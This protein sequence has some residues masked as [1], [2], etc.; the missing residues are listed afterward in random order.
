MFAAGGGSRKPHSTN[1]TLGNWPS[2]SGKATSSSTDCS[3]PSRQP[4]HE[5]EQ[6]GQRLWSDVLTGPTGPHLHEHFD[7]SAQDLQVWIQGTAAL[8]NLPWE[9]LTRENRFVFFEENVPLAR[10]IPHNT[11][12]LGWQQAR[13]QPKLRVLLVPAQPRNLG[14]VHG[15]ET[16]EE[17]RQRLWFWQALG[18]LDLEVLDHATDWNTLDRLR[19]RLQQRRGFDVVCLLAHGEAEGPHEAGGP[20]RIALVGAHGEPD[21]LAAR[22]LVPPM[23]SGGEL[24]RLV[25][26]GCCHLGRSDSRGAFGGI[27]QELLEQ[28]IPAV[29]S[30]QS[31]VSTQGAAVAIH[32]TLHSLLNNAPI[33]RAVLA[34]RHE[35]GSEWPLPVLWL[36]PSCDPIQPLLIV[37]PKPIS[38]LLREVQEGIGHPAI[39]GPTAEKLLANL[40]YVR[41]RQALPD[42]HDRARAFLEQQLC[43]AAEQRM[44]RCQRAN[45]REGLARDLCHLL[46]HCDALAG[47]TCEEARATVERP[48]RE[49]LERGLEH[50]GSQQ[51]ADAIRCFQAACEAE[52]DGENTELLW[53]ELRRDAWLHLQYARGNHDLT[54]GGLWDEAALER[55]S[56]G[57][58]LLEWLAAHAPQ[59]FSHLSQVLELRRQELEA[60]RLAAEARRP[61][62]LF[63]WTEARRALQRAHEVQPLFGEDLRLVETCL[64]L[65]EKLAVAQEAALARR[66]S[67]ACQ[68]FE[69]DVVPLY[70]AALKATS[71][72]PAA[73]SAAAWRRGLLQR[74]W[75]TECDPLR[76]RWRVARQVDELLEQVEAGVRVTCQGWEHA[77]VIQAL[78]VQAVDRERVVRLRARLPAEL[79][80]AWEPWLQQELDTDWPLC[81][82]LQHRWKDA[83]L[84]LGSLSVRSA[85]IVPLW[86]RLAVAGMALATDCER[87]LP[88]DIRAK[89]WSESLRAWSKVLGQISYWSHWAQPEGS[90]TQA[91]YERLRAGIREFVARHLALRDDADVLLDQASRLVTM[92]TVDHVELLDFGLELARQTL[93]NL[94][95]ARLERVWRTT[96]AQATR[97]N[98]LRS[99]CADIFS[100]VQI[101]TQESPD[102]SNLRVDL[103]EIAS[104]VLNGTEKHSASE[105]QLAA[106]Y[107]ERGRSRLWLRFGQEAFADLEQAYRLQPCSE[108]CALYVMAMSLV[109]DEEVQ[110]EDARRICRFARDEVGKARGR[111]P[112]RRLL[113]RFAQALDNAKA[114]NREHISALVETLFQAY[115]FED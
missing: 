90:W 51:W 75:Q 2:G 65:Q 92:E 66:W 55:Q 68:R 18:L 76:T 39:A 52:A 30:M 37:E 12:L 43:A 11:R 97:A 109:A 25:V 8:A 20:P 38:E 15:R 46:S 96:I 63:Q 58:A 22:D 83:H 102:D 77:D 71:N 101:R 81:L 3:I 53:R 82:V 31:T 114:L 94:D 10:T 95:F 107:L 21:W 42:A 89:H 78:A 59:R 32:A 112:E 62:H 9:V 91:S 79:P 105:E 1:K 36:H 49:P 34:C 74:W 111:W 69:L 24:P 44:G 50:E 27:S 5:L 57:L 40:R 60:A 14:P 99:T 23:T 41:E 45:D 104:R 70:E 72:A 48:L 67:E 88:E 28:G 84:A 108:N 7:Q 86:H 13:R 29:L 106:A 4:Q 115:A 33:G 47:P 35:L 64:A 17:L 93:Q 80:A 73:D 103:W 110:L 61:M 56:R 100:T 98:R 87:P 85:E 19:R 6:L 54:D 16:C 26:L 113:E